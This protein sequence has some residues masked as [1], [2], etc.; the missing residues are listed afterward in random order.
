VDWNVGRVLAALDSL[1]LRDNTI[2]VF[3]PDHGYQLGERGKWSK[4]G[5]LFEMGTR[6]PL[7]IRAP[8]VKGN[9]RSCYRTVQSLDIY[10]T[11]VDLC[12][13]PQQAGL[14]GKSLSS[15]LQNPSASWES[16]AFSIWSE[17][18][19]TVYGIAVRTERWRYV[20]FGEKAEHGAMLFDEHAD[21][22]ELTNLADHPEHAAVRSQLSELIARYNAN[23]I[24]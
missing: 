22:L 11:M 7:I 4:A 15:L 5:S 3:V 20:E 2:V 18:G 1:G 6:V 19:R 8:G 16:P 24:A 23:E 12:G 13:L 14:Q 10:P 9:G 17:D 21:P